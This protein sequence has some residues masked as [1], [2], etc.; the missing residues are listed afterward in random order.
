MIAKDLRVGGR[1]VQRWR[2]TWNEDDP[3]AL[4]SQGPASLPRPSQ[5]QFTQLETELAKGPSA[6]GWEDQRW[7]LERVKTRIHRRADLLQIRPQVEADL[8]TTERLTCRS[9]WAKPSRPERRGLE[10]TEGLD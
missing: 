8:P 7:T 10:H 2:Q 6:H 4:R 3:R 1:S 5:K 9:S